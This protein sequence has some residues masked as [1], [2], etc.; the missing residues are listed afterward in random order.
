[1]I[2]HSIFQRL[3]DGVT[4]CYKEVDE[5]FNSTS[6]DSSA[7]MTLNEPEIYTD[8]SGNLLSR[9]FG[10]K[11]F[12]FSVPA[13]GSAAWKQFSESVR[14]NARCFFQEIIQSTNDT[15]VERFGTELH[16]KNSK[17]VVHIRQVKRQYEERDRVVVV[18]QSH[19]DPLELDGQ[20][21][22]GAAFEEKGFF[23]I[24]HPSTLPK[25]FAMLQTCYRI[26]PH[27]PLRCVPQ[28]SLAIQVTEFVLNWMATTIPANH[29][30]I[31]DILVDQSLVCAA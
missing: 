17:A 12:P 2:G 22:Q 11:I 30:I 3:L 14:P 20:P 26:S 13:T 24:H 18:W 23:V 1:M 16:L 4:Q 7:V 5:V 28:N 15:V 21:L 8:E 27:S 10:S 25:G 31:E 19:V 9:V 6:I 29:Q